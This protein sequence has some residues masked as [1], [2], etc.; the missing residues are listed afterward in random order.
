MR[1]V[2]KLTTQEI[3]KLWETE[4]LLVGWDPSLVRSLE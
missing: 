2:G 4:D 3:S 1:L